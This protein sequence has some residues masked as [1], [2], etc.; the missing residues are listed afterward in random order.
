MNIFFLHRRRLT[1]PRW[2]VVALHCYIRKTCF[3]CTHDYCLLYRSATKFFF[4]PTFFFV[5]FCCWSRL[6]VVERHNR[7]KNNNSTE[8]WNYMW[9]KGDDDY[10]RLWNGEREFAHI[11]DNLIEL[12]S[13]FSCSTKERMTTRGERVSSAKNV[14]KNLLNTTSLQR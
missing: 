3:K 10:N 12:W 6:L 11:D 13:G 8:N 7:K 14:P 5:L 1:P 4:L 2:S 9:C